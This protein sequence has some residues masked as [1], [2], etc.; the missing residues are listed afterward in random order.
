MHNPVLKVWHSGSQCMK[1]MKQICLSEMDWS[2]SW[3]ASNWS[4][5]FGLIHTVHI[6]LLS[7]INFSYCAQKKKKKKTLSIMF[8]FLWCTMTNHNYLWDNTSGFHEISWSVMICINPLHK[9]GFVSFSFW[10]SCEENKTSIPAGMV[11]TFTQLGLTF[12]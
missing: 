10:K 1:H 6:I 8:E 2:K 12:L 9:A 3:P 11:L 7:L 5:F 4:W